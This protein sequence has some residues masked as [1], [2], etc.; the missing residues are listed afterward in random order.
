MGI[1]CLHQPNEEVGMAQPLSAPP[2]TVSAGTV[3]AS[4]VDLLS[5]MRDLFTCTRKMRSWI[6]DAGSMTVLAVVAE[7]GESRVSALAAALM[8]DV[9]TVSR[10]LTAL[11]RDG[12]VQWRPD[13]KDL[14]SH[15]VSATPVGLERL[16]TRPAPGID[17][18]AAR[19]QDWPEADVVTLRQLLHRFVSS[20]LCEPLAAGPDAIPAGPSTNVSSTS[21]TK[22][23]A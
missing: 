9:S 2:S 8:M 11:C 10:A 5:A 22:E 3:P 19:L 12:L 21:S 4:T 18:L 20:V 14:R 13:E 15:L 17:Q 1:P 23:S 16:A 6:S 7:H